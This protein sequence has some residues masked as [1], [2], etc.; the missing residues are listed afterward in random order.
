VKL[1][2]NVCWTAARWAASTL[3]Q[4]RVVHPERMPQEG[5]YILASNHASFL[6]PPL[7]GICS[8]GDVYYMARKTLMDIPILGNILP[9]LNLILVERDKVDTSALKIVIRNIREGKSVV[10]FPE[11]TR[12]LDGQLQPAKP[13]VGFVIA[14]TRAPVVPVRVFGSYEAFPKRGGVRFLPITVVI[15]ETIRFTDAEIGEGG[16][17]DFGRLSQLVMDAIADLR[18]PGEDD[19]PH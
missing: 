17:D 10:V 4:L 2:Y 8:R 3:F 11:G 15:G 19:G 1:V 13:G 5:G 16:R 7:V 18:L 6:D 9:H 14:K 12:T